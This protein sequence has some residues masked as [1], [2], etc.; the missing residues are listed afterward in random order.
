M[1]ETTMPPMPTEFP[2][3]YREFVI[4]GKTAATGKRWEGLSSLLPTVNNEAIESFL[5]IAAGGKITASRDDLQKI[6]KALSDADEYFDPSASSREIQVLSAALLAL[7]LK[8]E[9]DVAAR[10]AVA[11]STTDLNGHR[12]WNLPMSLV[13]LA[14]AAIVKIAELYRER[15]DLGSLNVSISKLDATKAKEFIAAGDVPS[16]FDAVGASLFSSL[17]GIATKMNK[18]LDA[19]AN[20]MRLQDEELDMLWW[21]FGE[22]SDDRQMT[23]KKLPAKERPLVLAKELADKTAYLPGPLSI[24]G[25]L[26]RAGVKEDSP[27]SIPDAVNACEASWLAKLAEVQSPSP[28]TRPLHFAI[29]RRLETGDETSWVAGWASVCG[30]APEMSFSPLAL[31]RLFYRERL[32]SIF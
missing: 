14:E 5:R 3:W 8:Q 19:T 7:L 25:L 27:I 15:P 4:D 12:T 21:V 1:S 23:F 32:L 20:F 31:G 22:R 24:D 13:S 11:I 17:S 26:V 18:A 30:I 9:S 16:A 6:G 28:L 2:L 29:H 10:A